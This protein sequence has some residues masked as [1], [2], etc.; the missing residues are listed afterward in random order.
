MIFNLTM[1]I[2]ENFLIK[3]K[4]KLVFPVDFILKTIDSKQIAIYF[5]A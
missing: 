2:F 1:K 4:E 5:A 3:L